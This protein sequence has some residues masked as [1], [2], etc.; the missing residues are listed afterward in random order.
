M[1]NQPILVLNKITEYLPIRDIL[2]LSRV[3]KKLY[4]KVSK[5]PFMKKLNDIKN[6]DS[7]SIPI[8]KLKLII[9]NFITNLL[10]LVNI[11]LIGLIIKHCNMREH[12]YLIFGLIIFHIFRK[13]LLID[14]K[15][16][17]IF[18]SI[19]SLVRFIILSGNF[20][21]E[22]GLATYISILFQIFILSFNKRDIWK[23]LMREIIC[24]KHD[25]LIFRKLYRERE[26][27]NIFYCE[28]LLL[29]FIN[30]NRSIYVYLIN[31]TDPE[32]Y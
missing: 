23:N 9:I 24:N 21:F 22:L 32:F 5:I 18:L 10:F 17:L 19:Y 6:E 29:A 2:N 25:C 15:K 7:K 28:L 1:E 11:C 27:S 31:D 26:I 30:D 8:V 16:I 3:S 14:N 20:L 13:K 4:Y 12:L